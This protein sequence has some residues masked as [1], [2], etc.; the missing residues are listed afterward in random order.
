MTLG[1]RQPR[2]ARQ[3]SSVRGSLA[4]PISESLVLGLGGFQALPLIILAPVMNKIRLRS[5]L[6]NLTLKR[7]R[8]PGVGFLQVLAAHASRNETHDS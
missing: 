3:Q 6:A 4:L 7:L 2:K 8:I 5:K 1:S